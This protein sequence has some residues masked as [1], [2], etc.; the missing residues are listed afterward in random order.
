[1]EKR[2]KAFVLSVGVVNMTNGNTQHDWSIYENEGLHAFLTSDGF[3]LFGTKDTFEIG[4]TVQMFNN[5]SGRKQKGPVKI[6]ATSSCE[7]EELLKMLKSNNY[8]Y[9]PIRS[10]KARPQGNR[11]LGT[12]YSV[13]GT[14]NL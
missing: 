2:L 9:Y 7:K 13:K 5:D 3:L 11:K 6:V 14:A 4:D 1:M 12:S 8:D 10:F